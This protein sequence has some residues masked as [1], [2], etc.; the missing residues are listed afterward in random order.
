MLSNN[1]ISSC[2]CAAVLLCPENRGSCY[3]SWKQRLFYKS[4]LTLHLQWSQWRQRPSTGEVAALTLP[5]VLN[6][7]SLPPVSP[8]VPKLEGECLW[9]CW[10]QRPTDTCRVIRC[11]VYMTVLGWEPESWLIS[12]FLSVFFCGEMRSCEALSVLT[13]IK[14]LKVA[15][16]SLRYACL[17]FLRSMVMGMC[18]RIWAVW[19]SSSLS[20]QKI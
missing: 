5:Y 6:A 17:C 7:W 10:V 15:L 8:T 14:E 3:S 11:Q 12:F 20:P 19:P 2:A 9:S 13:L 1:P 4:P 18:H 16:N